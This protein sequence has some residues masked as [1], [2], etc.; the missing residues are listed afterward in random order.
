[1]YTDT[2]GPLL[3]L[4]INPIWSL[5]PDNPNLKKKKKEEKKEPNLPIRKASCN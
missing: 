2:A 5:R 4:E 3:D 1:M